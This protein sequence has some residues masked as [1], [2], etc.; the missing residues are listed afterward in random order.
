MHNHEITQIGEDFFGGDDAHVPVEHAVG[1]HV[2]ETFTFLD[3]VSPEETFKASQDHLPEIFSGSEKRKIKDSEGRDLLKYYG[4]DECLRVLAR[5]EYIA[6]ELKKVLDETNILDSG[7]IHLVS[8]E[9]VEAVRKLVLRLTPL[10]GAVPEEVWKKYP[11][12]VRQRERDMAKRYG[13]GADA[14]IY[15][16]PAWDQVARYENPDT[17]AGTPQELNF[18]HRLITHVLF[19]PIF[20]EE[21]VLPLNKRIEL[22]NRNG[23]ELP[24]K[25][26]GYLKQEDG[27]YRTIDVN[28]MKVRMLLHDIGRWAT[29][30]QYL[31]ESMPDLIAH[32][33]GIEPPLI[34]FEFDHEFRYFSENDAEEV[35]AQVDPDTISTKETVIQLSEDSLLHPNNIPIEESTFHLIDF[36]A[37]RAKEDDLKSSEIRSLDQL[38][39]HAIVRAAGYNGALKAFLESP[40]SKSANIEVKIAKAFEELKNSKDPRMAQFCKREI[41]FL[42]AILPFFGRCA[43]PDD[44]QAAIPGLLGPVGVNLDE[45]LDKGQIEFEKALDTFELYA[46]NKEGEVPETP[47]RSPGQYLKDTLVG[48][49][50]VGRVLGGMAFDSARNKAASLKDRVAAQKNKL[51]LLKKWIGSRRT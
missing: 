46:Y 25:V 45:I 8:D 51:S 21:M 24:P 43:K 50:V 10:G 27:N 33:L 17:F 22:A 16:Y 9:T 15:S 42:R 44:G 6:I 37:K 38:V 47:R 28:R 36:A 18:Y 26:F 3:G 11:E 20:V 41:Q 35:D 34:Q 13:Y 19:T 2:R 23:E 30:H 48:S 7:G 40:E 4:E 14:Q 39:E 5:T 31:H 1:E 12:S 32:F 29:H 49:K